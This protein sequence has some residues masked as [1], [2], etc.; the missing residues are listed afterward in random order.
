[1]KDEKKLPFPQLNKSSSEDLLEIN[2][3][4]VLYLNGLYDFSNSFTS[5]TK[6]E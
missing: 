3:I 1:M 4:L 5:Q 2:R 6:E